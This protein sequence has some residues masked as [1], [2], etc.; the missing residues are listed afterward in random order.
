MKKTTITELSQNNRYNRY[1]LVMATAKGARY[2]IDRENYEKEHPEYEQYKL[3]T[4]AS[5]GNKKNDKEELKPVMEAIDMINRGE[6]VIRKRDENGDYVVVH[7]TAAEAA[8]EAVDA[9]IE[10]E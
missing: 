2:V 4:G 9:P 5:S 6:I 3:L 10:E 7:P 8:G 1:T